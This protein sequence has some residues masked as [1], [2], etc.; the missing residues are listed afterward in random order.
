[1]LNKKLLSY[2]QTAAKGGLMLKTEKTTS[3]RESAS[4]RLARL[5]VRVAEMQGHKPEELPKPKRN[6][7]SRKPNKTKEFEL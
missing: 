2:P 6:P 4:E 3:P 5:R 1:M 7:L